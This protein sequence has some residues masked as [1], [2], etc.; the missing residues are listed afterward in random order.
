MPQP[1]DKAPS[2]VARKRTVRKTT[3]SRQTTVKRAA[4]RARSPV[5]VVRKAPTPLQ[6]SKRHA[7][8]RLRQHLVVAVICSFVFGISIVVGISDPGVIDTN[9]I[10]IERNE[11]I[12]QGEAVDASIDGEVTTKVIPVQNQDIRLNGGGVGMG[13]LDA[14]KQT[15]SPPEPELIAT[16]TDGTIATSTATTSTEEAIDAEDSDTFSTSSTEVA[17]N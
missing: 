12:A 2:G 13:D 6:A 1:A 14:S 17:V 8:Q 3:S 10:I 16:S 15:V 11:R 9:A 4:P 5:G 7:Q